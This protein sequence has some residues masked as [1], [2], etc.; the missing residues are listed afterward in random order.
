MS[1]QRAPLHILVASSSSATATAPGHETMSDEGGEE[2]PLVDFMQGVVLEEA[3][4]AA[5]R[6]ARQWSATF[7][8]HVQL[9]S[10]QSS[11]PTTMH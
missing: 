9:A 11:N 5:V 3:T 8:F 7:D 4:P 2:G 1:V 10:L 6:R